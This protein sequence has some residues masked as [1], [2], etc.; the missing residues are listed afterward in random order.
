M[1][2][3][4][5]IIGKEQEVIKMN[6]LTTEI[7]NYRLTKKK[8]AKY[9]AIIQNLVSEIYSKLDTLN[10]YGLDNYVSYI[11]DIKYLID[12]NLADII[13]YDYVLETNIIEVIDILESKIKEINAKLEEA[14]IL[15]KRKEFTY[16]DV[17][18]DE[19][20]SSYRN[21]T[22]TENPNN[23]NDDMAMLQDI[24]SSI[25]SSTCTDKEEFFDSEYKLFE[26]EKGKIK[27][28]F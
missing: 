15:I 8:I 3:F 14:K 20:I 7:S 19:M 16:S 10:Q 9:K 24:V 1:P 25:Q 23:S 6:T 13:M 12:E 21:V 4:F 18:L 28:T 26:V 11:S 5:H 2:L 17:S 22:I 27:Q